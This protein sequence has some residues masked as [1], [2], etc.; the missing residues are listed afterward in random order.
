[1][2]DIENA[3]SK[4]LNDIVGSQNPEQVAATLSTLRRI[5]DNIIQHPNDDKYRQ[6]RLTGKTFSSKVWQYPA[7]EELMKMSGWVVEDDHVRLRDDSCVQIVSRLLKSLCEFQGTKVEHSSVATGI[8]PIPLHV[9]QILVEMLLNGHVF[10][11]RMLLKHISISPSGRVYSE[12]GTSVNL[13][14]AATIGQQ[15]DI[16]KLL[17]HD[18][19]VDPYALGVGDKT[20][21]IFTIFSTAPQS[22]IIDILKCCDIKLS[23][24]ASG[25]ALLHAA[26]FANCLDVVQFLVEECKN[27][28]INITD[29][30]LRTPLHTAYLAGCT[31][32]AQYL[33]QHGA[34]VFAVDK[35]GYTPYEY[36]D[37]V[38]ELV[39][40]SQHILNKRRIHHVPYSTEHLYYMKLVRNQISD[41]EAVSLTMEKFP[42]LKEDGPTQPHH[43]IDR[44]AGVKE[45]IQYVTKGVI[46]DNP[47]K[48][49]SQ[50]QRRHVL[51]T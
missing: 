21:Y 27:V 1:M 39:L 43:D 37:D 41:K 17:L 32:I 47:W 26:V 12:S 50:E 2:S 44:T 20:P 19:S 51:F 31:Q 29:N 36:I 33:I 24:K 4:Q 13:L 22:F 35:Y 46:D 25:I 48:Q 30:D 5:F 3:L 7:G 40:F 23:Y 49:L 18:C 10:L 11:V 9:F 45:F 42:S 34:S 14:I 15:L 6:I 28:D 38:L 16:I 8:V